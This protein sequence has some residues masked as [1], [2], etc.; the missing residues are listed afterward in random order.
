MGF[1]VCRHLGAVG[2]NIAIMKRFLPNR[3]ISF[4][5]NTFILLP[6][7]YCAGAILE[8]NEVFLRDF[9]YSLP[10]LALGIYFLIT[11]RV[12]L[13][14]LSI[15]YF[16]HV[17]FDLTYLFVIDKSY[18]I[19]FYEELCIVYDLIVAL[20]LFINRNNNDRGG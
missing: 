9:W 15:S 18:M 11:K 12:I 5:K 20:V 19:N 8:S 2:C 7:I 16:S 1:F 6:I 17:L 4:F 3:M 10:F 14:V 13:V